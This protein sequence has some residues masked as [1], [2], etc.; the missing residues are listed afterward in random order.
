MVMSNGEMYAYL[1]DE[2]EFN[3]LNSSVYYVG[4]NTKFN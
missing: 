4:E 3:E 2:E 1:D